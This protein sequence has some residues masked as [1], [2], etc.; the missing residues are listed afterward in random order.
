MRLFQY[1]SGE[2]K[3]ISENRTVTIS[4]VFA[5]LVPLVYAMIILS[6]EWGPLDNLDNV[7]VAIV[8]NDEGADNEGEYV[9][10]GEQLVETLQDDDQLGWDF[11]TEEEAIRGMNNQEYFMTVIVPPNFSEKTITVMDDDPQHPELQYIQNEGMHYQ[12]TTVT[13]AAI[14]SLQ[15]QLATQIT[16]TYVETV[17]DQLGEVRDGFAEAHDGSEQIQDGV[18]QLKDGSDEILMNLV[19]SAPDINR[20]ANGAQEAKDG[21]GLLLS[22]LQEKLPDINR[23]ANGGSQLKEGSVQLRDGAGQL[24]DGTKEAKAGTEQLIQQGLGQLVPGSQ[25]LYEGTLEAQNGVHETM[26]KMEKLQESLGFLSTLDKDHVSYDGI[27][28]ETLK[29]LN[30]SMSE[31]PQKK[32]DFQRL[33]DGAKQLRDGVHGDLKDGIHQ[34]DDGLGQLRDG[35]GQL[36]A[37]TVELD[38]GATELSDG[39]QTV[40]SGW[41]E[42]IYNVDILDDGLLQIADGTVTVEGG[43]DALTDGMTQ[44][45]DGLEQLLE[46][47]GELEEGLR[48]GKE[49]T[50]DLNPT[51][52]NQQMFASPVVLNGEAINKFQYYRDANAPYIITLALFV[53]V[54]ALSFV[55]PFRKPAVMPANG[56][57]WFTGKVTQLATLTVIQAL[58][59][60]L[61]S[62][63]ILKLQVQ[64]S[65]ALILFSVFVS[66]TFLMIVLFLIASAGNIGRFIA[67]IF[68]VIQLSTTGSDLPIHMLPEGLRDLST[69]LPFTYSIDAYQNIITLGDMSKVWSDVTVLFIYFALFAVLSLIV[70]IIRYRFIKSDVEDGF[71]E[72]TEVAG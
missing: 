65:L 31:N 64:S 46:G 39:T 49:R 66:L 11:V 21:T 26:E 3:R 2:F 50:A 33:V 60:P 41:N 59:I 56:L 57:T 13:N 4:I 38:E 51:V 1:I 32:K 62:L 19:E 44:V 69:F 72:E 36:S 24:H 48:G 67:L 47:S 23:L 27:F 52:E 53:G 68:V 35:A 20:L 55:V 5:L 58:I 54:F 18:S 25:E 12:G 42:L 10:V 16:E 61:F 22:T 37:G 30:E 45:D 70:F 8:N 43:W 9:N 7:P 17:F 40:L 34:L 6:P 71:K 63:F 15:S 29:E 28:N 14:E